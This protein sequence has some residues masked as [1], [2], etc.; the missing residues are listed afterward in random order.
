MYASVLS[1]RARYYVWQFKDSA[2]AAAFALDD[3]KK[4][5]KRMRSNLMEPTP[6]Y[7]KDDRVRY[8]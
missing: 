7:F 8:I 1:A 4:G 3:Y 6:T 2:Q 5:L